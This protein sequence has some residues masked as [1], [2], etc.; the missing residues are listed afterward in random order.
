MTAQIAERLLH[1]GR[2]FALCSLPLEP[3]LESHTARPR[4]RVPSSAL[5]R[6]Y[7]GTWR[8]MK[9][10]LYL[11]GI[12][13]ELQDGGAASLHSVF[14]HE[15][16]TVFAF[17]FSGELRV[18]QGKMLEYVHR[19]FESRF[20]RD[21]LFTCEAGVITGKK[22]QRNGKSDRPGPEGYQIGA[23]TSFRDN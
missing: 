15:H 17:W 22:V 11:V 9:Q 2:E 3:Y 1:D 19:G 18:P 14:P 8:I 4:F 6:G 16:D 12:A 13:G 20:E 23:A 7:I 21:L 10:R 5:R